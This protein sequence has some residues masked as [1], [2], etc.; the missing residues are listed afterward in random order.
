MIFFRICWFSTITFFPKFQPGIRVSNSSDPDQPRCVGPDLGLNCLQRSAADDKISSWQVKSS[1]SCLIFCRLLIFLNQ[2]FQKKYFKN[3]IRESNSLDLDQEFCHSW[4]GFRLFEKVNSRWKA[5]KLKVPPQLFAYWVNFS[6]FVL[7]CC[8]FFSKL[9]FSKYSFECQ[10]VWIQIRHF[11]LS[12]LILVWTVYK[13]QQ[14]TTKFAS[15][16]QSYYGWIC[17]DPES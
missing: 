2:L 15:G 17:S 16:R 7:V 12:V 9:T 13:D 5:W 10:T 8:L 1:Q 3:T 11:I 14:Q 4:S 6:S